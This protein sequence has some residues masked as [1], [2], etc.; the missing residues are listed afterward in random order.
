MEVIE[1]IHGDRA[2]GDGFVCRTDLVGQSTCQSSDPASAATV[3]PRLSSLSRP[4]WPA[5]RAAAVMSG[6][7]RCTSWLRGDDSAS[8]S[9]RLDRAHIAS[10]H[11]T[12][13]CCWDALREVGR[14][15]S[16]IGVAHDAILRISPS[17]CH[18]AAASARVH[19]PPTHG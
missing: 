3:R 5:S 18:M 8:V 13:E 11:A 16:I 4:A 6:Q 9:V 1:V 2:K 10:L 12:G 7:G 15:L 17:C 19:E 14:D